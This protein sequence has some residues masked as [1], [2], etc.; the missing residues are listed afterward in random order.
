MN[1]QTN[2]LT[3]PAP[4]ARDG[5]APIA[6]RILFVLIGVAVVVALQAPIT[7]LAANV[8]V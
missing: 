4:Q 5:E 8:I 6:L 2:T 1:T 7:M 3:Q